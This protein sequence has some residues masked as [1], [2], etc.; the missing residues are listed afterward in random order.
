M[1]SNTNGDIGFLRDP[2]RLN[3][4]LTRARYGLIIVGNAKTLTT[5]P[6]W[7][8]LINYYNDNK[9]IYEGDLMDFNQC[10]LKLKQPI[11]FIS[12]NEER[13]LKNETLNDDP[14][15]IEVSYKISRF[16]KALVEKSKSNI[17]GSIF[18][19]DISYKENNNTESNISFDYKL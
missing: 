18:S 11:R 12:K 10:H 3:V 4:A 19:Y 14:I 2:N 9:L 8:N 5:N 7:N 6:L 13:L 17:N 15:S 16:Q 1:R